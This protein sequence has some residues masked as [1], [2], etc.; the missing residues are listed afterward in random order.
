MFRADISLVLSYIH[1][2]RHSQQFIYLLS[3]TA[4]GFG[5]KRFSVVRMYPND[6]QRDK[7]PIRRCRD[8]RGTR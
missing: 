4:G 2:V 1:H 7:T 6:I 3:T 5:D 8:S